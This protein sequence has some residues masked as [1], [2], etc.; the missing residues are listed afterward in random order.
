MDKGE[1]MH[2]IEEMEGTRRGEGDSGGG[3][4][5][6]VGGG[7]IEAPGRE[8]GKQRAKVVGEDSKGGRTARREG[9][10]ADIMGQA[11][12]RKGQQ[13]R[14]GKIKAAVVGAE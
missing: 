4:G 12:T 11:R 8:H 9:A 13:Q 3:V 1:R 10:E 7:R 14:K 6:Q 2:S 5:D